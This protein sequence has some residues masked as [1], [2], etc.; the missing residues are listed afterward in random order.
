MAFADAFSG[1][2][3]LVILDHGAGLISLYGHTSSIDVKPGQMVKK[4]DVLGKSG[5]TGRAA[6]DHLHFGMF[7]HGVP[8][9]PTEWW[10]EK[11]TKEHILDRFPK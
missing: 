7:L 1:F 2:G 3:N 9:N 4:K 10:D 5:T 11:W 6:G 8:V